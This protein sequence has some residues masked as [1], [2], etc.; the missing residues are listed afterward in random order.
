VDTWQEVEGTDVE[1][2]QHFNAGQ[3][4]FP[5]AE[6]GLIEVRSRLSGK[7]TSHIPMEGCL[8]DA[9]C[10]T[11]FSADGSWAL[12]LERTGG[13]FIFKNDLLNSAFTVWDLA[14]NKA[15]ARGEGALRDLEN[16][17]VKADGSLIR[18]DSINGFDSA[19]AEIT[20]WWTFR[21]HFSGLQA[22]K[23]GSIT[24]VPLAAYGSSGH[25]QF[26]STCTIDA[27]EGAIACREGIADDEGG[28]LT[29]KTEGG[30]I[31]AMRHGA[32]GEARLGVLPLP[33]AE[34]SA[35]L[36][37]RILGYSH[38]Q[39]AL[40][41]CAD[42]DQRQAGCFI[43]D[44][45]LN[46]TLETPEDISF[47]RFSADGLSASFINRTANAL[48]L[49]D[50]ASKKM[51][52][53]SPYQSRST[54]LNAVFSSN[55]TAFHYVIQYQNNA[56]DLSV[57]TLEPGN[58]KS[59]GRTSLRAAGVISPTVFLESKDGGLW[60]FAGKSGEVWLLSPQKGV[61]LHRFQAHLDDIIGM[62]LSPDGTWLV[63][64]GENGIIKFW[65]VGE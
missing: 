49:Y 65:G 32:S 36:R 34:G 43:Y 29:Q 63:T 48:F 64:M 16:V 5:W 58:W 1:A 4:L 46:E 31:T 57:E 38:A 9:P 7:T 10:E 52:R 19:D 24:F 11:R 27:E 22:D 47:L 14:K 51:T 56:N 3:L 41:Y 42:A 59:L 39:Q 26:C 15:A 54:P 61:L 30:Q 60:A 8:W 2:A 18:A 37:V 45:S 20:G 53:K 13:Q 44:T 40:F 62:A 55:G 23:D 35:V 21:N 50:L 12:I 25:C 17:L 28:F 33:D 6:D